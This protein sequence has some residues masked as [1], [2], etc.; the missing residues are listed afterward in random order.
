MVAVE[1]RRTFLQPSD[2][3]C[4]A[5][6]WGQ[7]VG[8]RGSPTTFCVVHVPMNEGVAVART[9]EWTERPGLVGRSRPVFPTR[10]SCPVVSVGK[11][12]VEENVS[13]SSEE[14]QL[15][16]KSWAYSA[17]GRTSRKHLS[18]PPHW[19]YSNLFSN[20]FRRLLPCFQLNSILL[21][22]CQLNSRERSTFSS[23]DGSICTF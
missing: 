17:C 19:T 3:S 21:R 16:E 15:V 9:Q 12:R 5:V 13:L 14:T 1:L 6:I 8:G 7:E 23:L 18:K 10:S 20:F 11:F 22:E 4:G 2:P